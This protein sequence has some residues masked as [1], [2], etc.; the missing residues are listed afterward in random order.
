MSNGYSDRDMIDLVLKGQQGIQEQLALLGEKID[1]VRYK[2][3]AHRE[4]DLLRISNLEGWKNKGIGGI[5]LSLLSAIGALA[6]AM[7]DL[8]RVGK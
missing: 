2:G 8:L 3:C 7:V 5:I 1:A 4:S 6:V